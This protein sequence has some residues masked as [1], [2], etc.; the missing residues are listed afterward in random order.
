ML[1]QPKPQTS[2]KFT[3]KSYPRRPSKKVLG[4]V[5]QVRLALKPTNR[6]ATLLGFLLGGFVPLASFVVAHHEVDSAR[7]LYTQLSSYLVLGG[8]MY[9]F[10]TVYG[11]AKMAVG[12]PLKACGFVI[13]LEGIMVA[14]S[15]HLL[16]IAALTYLMVINGIATGCRLSLG[17][18]AVQEMRK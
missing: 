15:N 11:W 17:G 9:S 4:V 14:S 5:E 18:Q 16:S 6:L 1:A 7:A 3:V 10:P 2:P 13:L 12:S 8:L